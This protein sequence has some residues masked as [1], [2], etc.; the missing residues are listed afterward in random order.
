MGTGGNNISTSGIG[1]GNIATMSAGAIGK[2]SRPHITLNP[3]STQLVDNLNM[4]MP[5]ASDSTSSSTNSNT[6]ARNNRNG[7]SMTANNSSSSNSS[8]S[9]AST[10][11]GRQLLNPNGNNNVFLNSQ[12]STLTNTLRGGKFQLRTIFLFYILNFISTNS[13][14]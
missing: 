1:A 2:N 4:M 5:N 7:K 8:S 13:T 14:S 11:L 12:L 10:T 3:Y 6:S 9:T